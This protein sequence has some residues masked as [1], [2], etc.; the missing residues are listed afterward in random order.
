MASMGRPRSI[1][2][3]ASSSYDE[4]HYLVHRERGKAK[5]QPC[6]RCGLPAYE[7]CYQHNGDTII[8]EQGRD[9]CRDLSC[10]SPM[11]RSC[12]RFLDGA[13]H[14]EKVAEKGRRSSN[15][16]AAR[17]A[18]DPHYDDARK[19]AARINAVRA[20]EAFMQDPSHLQKLAR[21]GVLGGRALAAKAKTNPE[22]RSL[23]IE[24]A[25]RNL[26]KCNSDTRSCVECGHT[27]TPG[28]V[29]VHQYYS[30]HQ[31]TS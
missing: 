25:K 30:K 26:A 19:V 10:Y 8:D 6:S 15:V 18:A 1:F 28:G 7:W 5:G 21:A 12:H 13:V 9:F 23:L 22:L 29:G 20:R 4:V 24:S 11:C 31:G 27:S 2:L 17:R 16:Q 3:T 14:P